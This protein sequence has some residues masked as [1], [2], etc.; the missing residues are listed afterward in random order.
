MLVIEGKNF[1]DWSHDGCFLYPLTVIVSTLFKE[2]EILVWTYSIFN[3]CYII[4]YDITSP[5]VHFKSTLMKKQ[6]TF[7]KCIYSV[8]WRI[9]NWRLKK[10]DSQYK[11]QISGYSGEGGQSITETEAWEAQTVRGKM[12]SRMSCNDRGHAVSIL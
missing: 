4:G 3:K 10:A 12:R 9:K 2:S 11:E 7:W 5:T 8:E 1:R 6:I